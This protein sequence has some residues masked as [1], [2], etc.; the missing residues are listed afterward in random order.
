MKTPS[1][2]LVNVI[3][4]IME[5]KGFLLQEDIKNYKSQIATGKMKAEDWLLAVEKALGK[6]ESQ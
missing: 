4:P 6:G 2:E 5:E 3:F 1:E